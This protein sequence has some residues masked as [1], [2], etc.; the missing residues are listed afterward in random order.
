MP[1]KKLFFIAGE[2]SG[3]F[4][5]A[6]LVRELKKLN[7]DLLCRG[8]GGSEMAK[9]GVELLCDLTKEAAL[10]LG[11]VLRKYF[12][13]RSIFKKALS[14]V[15]IF[16][17]DAIILIDY[18]GFNLRFAKKINKRFPIIYYISP[19]I[20]AWGK[21]RIHTI[22]RT[23]DHMIVF[24][25]FEAEL[26]QKEGVSVSWVGHPLIDLKQPSKTRAELRA[27]WV[28][29]ISD[30]TKIVGLFPGSRQTEV[31]RI[32]PEMLQ[33]AKRIYSRTP[34][35]QFLL[36]QSNTLSSSLYEK[37]LSREQPSY[38][39]QSIRNRSFDL[40]YASDFALVSSGTSTLEAALAST[41]FVILYK[42][43]WS[44]FFLGRRLIRI[45]YIGLVNVVAGRKI[46]PEFIQH[47]IK[48]ET[49]A[50]EAH[51]LLEHQ[52]LREKMILDLKAI[53]VKLGDSG[54]AERAAKVVLKVISSK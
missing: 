52:D 46:V 34:N 41:P 22:R 40:L 4:Q 17:P 28:P 1:P 49:I 5:G 51:F 18:P 14:E 6:H 43:A 35:V 16:R 47:E 53:Q 29:K 19:Q 38:P 26:Y 3:D 15:Q 36:S 21:R 9:E 12:L 10:G 33:V 31:K 7:P 37:I 2:A 50:Q 23:V 44:T 42:T 30:K 27:E 20:W 54:A 24:F 25:N 8:L 32:L 48:P 11:D 39:I 13:F 45:P